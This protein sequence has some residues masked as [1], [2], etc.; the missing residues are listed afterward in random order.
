MTLV[1]FHA[2]FMI[3]AFALLVA[4]AIIAMFMRQKRWWFKSHRTLGVLST[5]CFLCGFV[6]AMAMIAV[7]SGY[8]F[9]SV[10][11]RL[12]LFTTILSV[13]T[14]MLGFLQFGK[15]FPQSRIAM[16]HRWTAR[17]TLLTACTTLASGLRIL[18]IF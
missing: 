16:L 15:Y 8:H 12:G 18:G 1:Y 3:D 2:G 9:R 4:G 5:L 7:S 6:S 13:V 14:M 11:A 17:V 10:H